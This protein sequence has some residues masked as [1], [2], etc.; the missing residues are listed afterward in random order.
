MLLGSHNV[1]FLFRSPPPPTFRPIQTRCYAEPPFQRAA[2][3]V[4]T[5]D[6]SGAFSP[7]L[8]QATRRSGRTATDSE[9]PIPSLTD[10][11][12]RAYQQIN[13]F[14]LTSPPQLAPGVPLISYPL[15][16]SRTKR[17]GAEM[18]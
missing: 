12:G 4:D 16:S 15:R 11:F 18:R 7:S 13:V 14:A 6:A 10:A 5:K 17:S 1:T 2:A 8:L 9:G 3:G